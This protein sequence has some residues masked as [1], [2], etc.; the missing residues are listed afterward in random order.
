MRWMKHWWVVNMEKSGPSV[1][2][3]ACLSVCARR[4]VYVCVCVCVRQKVP[5]LLCAVPAGRVAVRMA[6]FPV[7]ALK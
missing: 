1:C 5:G 7:S 2:M 4:H 6:L 3:P